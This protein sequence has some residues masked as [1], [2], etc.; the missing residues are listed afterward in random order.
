M[1]L[2]T[3]EKPRGLGRTEN[4]TCRKMRSLQEQEPQGGGLFLAPP[5]GSRLPLSGSAFP[6]AAHSSK[7]L[8]VRLLRSAQK[9]RIRGEFA[10]RIAGAQPDRRSI[11]YLC[12]KDSPHRVHDSPLR[13]GIADRNTGVPQH[14]AGK[15]AAA[16]PTENSRPL[17]GTQSV[18]NSSLT[19]KY[20]G[21]LSMKKAASGICADTAKISKQPNA[22]SVPRLS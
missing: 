4:R 22:V 3:N 12:E 8:R 2:R 10:S 7:P 20:T 13:R 5:C 6:A 17:T 18:K 9:R 16:Y 19:I 15:Q 21:R 14:G 11:S 1:N